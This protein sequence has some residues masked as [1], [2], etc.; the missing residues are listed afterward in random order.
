[1]SD[2]DRFQRGLHSFLV[3]RVANLQACGRL[4]DDQQDI[5]ACP[6]TIRR[7]PALAVLCCCSSSS[8]ARSTFSWCHRH[9]GHAVKHLSSALD[10]RHRRMLSV[11]SHEAS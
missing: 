1:M 10:G 9:H 2:Q 4:Q 6:N 11:P 7:H 5:Q 8:L 3:V